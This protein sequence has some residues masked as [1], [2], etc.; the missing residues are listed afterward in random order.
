MVESSD[1][2]EYERMRLENIRR[3]KELLKELAI[4]MAKI[5]K[6]SAAPLRRHIPKKPIKKEPPQPQRVSARLRGIKAQKI[7]ITEH[8]TI[9]GGKRLMDVDLGTD[10]RPR[11]KKINTLNDQDH[12]NLQNILASAAEQ[13]DDNDSDEDIP[14]DPSLQPLQ[15]DL[16]KL[17]V[18]HP[19][20]SVRVFQDKISNCLFHP[21]T[22]KMLGIVTSGSGHLSFWDIDNEDEDGDPVTYGYRPSLSGITNAKFAK[23]DSSTLF[24]SSYDGT[25]QT[26]DM[27]ALSFAQIETMNKEAVSYFDLVDNGKVV[28]FGT[29][30]GDLGVRD[31][32]TPV[33][34]DQAYTIST[35]KIGC[36]H[37]NPKLD[38]LVIASSNDRTATLWDRRN[39]KPEEPLQ[40]LE[41]G[42]SVTGAFWSPTGK[43]IATSSYDDYLRVFDL[44]DDQSLTLKGRISHNCHT[45]KWVP[46]FRT[47]WNENKRFGLAHPHFVVGNMN[48]RLSIFSGEAVK[49]VVDLYDGSRITAVPAVNE[50]HPTLDRLAVLSGTGTGR[51][52]CWT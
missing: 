29:T 6:A 34:Q 15:D 2:S 3:N 47:K 19:W 48:H 25:L 16:N 13:Q 18:R 41:H 23:H 7:E 10:D 14:L 24:L 22:T 50:F 33:D 36:V 35:K 40:V 30:D 27:N 37:I 39:I 4:P 20:T 32:R 8:D 44:S 51:V 12:S 28:I 49:K 17:E 9:A 26:F 45:G 1:L 21:S 31:L 46:L 38:H 52:V 5:P 11:A 43:Q 42:Y